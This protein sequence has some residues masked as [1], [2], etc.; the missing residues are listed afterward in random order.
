MPVEFRRGP[1]DIPQ[2]GCRDCITRV[3]VAR[4]WEE[5]LQ[6]PGR[7]VSSLSPSMSSNWVDSLIADR[8]RNEVLAS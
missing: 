6:T 2:A 3:G 4:E 8:V 7:G 1:L 5:E